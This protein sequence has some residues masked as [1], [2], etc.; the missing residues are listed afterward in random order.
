M[1]TK[2]KLTIKLLNGELFEPEAEVVGD[3]GLHPSRRDPD[4][5][6]SITHVPTMMSFSG[7]VPKE[8]SGDWNK[9]RRARLL[10]WMEKVQKSLPKDWEAMKKFTVDEVRNNPRMSVPVRNRIREMCLET[11][12]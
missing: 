7:A 8:I 3:L 4:N 11:K 1:A 10:K 5:A 6:L 2:M 12:K 9:K